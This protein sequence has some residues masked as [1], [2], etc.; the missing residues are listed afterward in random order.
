MPAPDGADRIHLLAMERCQR[1]FDLGD[2]ISQNGTSWELGGANG[3]YRR[4]SDQVN[5]RFAPL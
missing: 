5:I 3:I 4:E 2:S 1:M